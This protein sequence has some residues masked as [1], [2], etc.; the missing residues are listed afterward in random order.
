MQTKPFSQ[1]LLNTG[2]SYTSYTQI[3]YTQDDACRR[4]TLQEK[5]AARE[6]FT[7]SLALVESRVAGVIARIQSGLPLEGTASLASPAAEAAL[8]KEQLALSK[9]QLAERERGLVRTREVVTSLEAMV[10]TERQVCHIPAQLT[11]CF[12]K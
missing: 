4:V 12:F 9:S 2:K 3:I 5:E 11:P 6:E 10:A 8:L 1:Q 7:R